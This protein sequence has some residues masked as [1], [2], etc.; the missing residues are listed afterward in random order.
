MSKWLCFGGM[1]VGVSFSFCHTCVS[2]RLLFKWE[3]MEKGCIS[4]G[5]WHCWRTNPSP[6]KWMGSLAGWLLHS[7]G[8]PWGIRPIWCRRARGGH[9]CL[10]STSELVVCTFCGCM[11]TEGLRLGWSAIMR[12]GKS[13]MNWGQWCWTI[14]WTACR[15]NQHSYLLDWFYILLQ[16]VDSEQLTDLF[17]NVNSSVS[18]GP[19]ILFFL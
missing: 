8:S 5:R 4:A 16:P 6:C 10:C 17:L 7:S 2:L 13:V 1:F 14:F 15:S 19:R 11:S 18:K 3:V 12:S 9:P